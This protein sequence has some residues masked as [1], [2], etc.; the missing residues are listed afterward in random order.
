MLFAGKI[1]IVCLLMGL[2]TIG[3]V[4]LRSWPG[5]CQAAG[6]IQEN[7]PQETVEE[8]NKEES[9]NVEYERLEAEEERIRELL[10]EKEGALEAK[11]REGQ[12]E[13]MNLNEELRSIQVQKIVLKA[14]ME[15]TF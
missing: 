9:I 2:L 4:G 5:I 10:Q 7:S 8:Y 14:R 6:N 13:V 1:K 12:I 11:D 15:E 3:E